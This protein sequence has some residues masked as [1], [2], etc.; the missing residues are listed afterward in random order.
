MTEGI[1]G[2][3]G[4]FVG[5]VITW[6]QSYYANRRTELKNAK[7]LAIRVVCILDKF[8]EDC[9]DVVKDDGLQFG[10]RTPEGCLEPQISVPQ[11]PVFPEDVDWRSIDQELM[12]KILSF[13]SDIAAGN[14]LIDF[15]QNI[16]G[17]P[18]YEEWFDERRYHYATFGLTADRLAGELCSKYNIKKKR[19][20][21]W[22][23]SADLERELSAGVQRRQKRLASYQTFI[24]KTSK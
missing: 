5:A 15:T 21:N 20:N 22:D 7:Y 16:S 18:D 12:Y 9:A 19:Y 24:K 3:I 23:P 4:V 17:P 1:F 8:M 11:I 10:Q 13:P 14:K 6:F 2:L